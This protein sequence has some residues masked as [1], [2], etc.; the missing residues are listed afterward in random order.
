MRAALL[1][2]SLFIAI[3]PVAIA[4][5]YLKKS[6]IVR[7]TFVMEYFLEVYRDTLGLE[8]DGD[9]TADEANSYIDRALFN[10][11]LMFV[12]PSRFPDTDPIVARRAGKHAKLVGTRASKSPHANDPVGILSKYRAG[13][14]PKEKEAAIELPNFPI[15]R[16]RNE[17]DYTKLVRSYRKWVDEHKDP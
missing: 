10:T 4:E 11:Y 3:V 12:G 9:L 14:L 5:D 6:A 7:D 16:I 13:I 8:K 2:T 15:S 1:V 17:V